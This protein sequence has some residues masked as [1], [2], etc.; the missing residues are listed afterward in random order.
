MAFYAAEYT[1]CLYISGKVWQ[2]EGFHIIDSIIDRAYDIYSVLKCYVYIC[3]G[4][5]Y[6]VQTKA[7]HTQ[8]SQDKAE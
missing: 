4:S 2:D 3:K 1:F 7:Q 6:S 8:F 5:A